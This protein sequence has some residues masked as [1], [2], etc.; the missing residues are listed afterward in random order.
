MHAEEFRSRFSHKCR[1]LLAVDEQNRKNHE[2]LMKAF[3]APD[4]A[5]RASAEQIIPV[6]AHALFI[7]QS[8]HFLMFLTKKVVVVVEISRDNLHSKA[9]HVTSDILRLLF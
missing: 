6:E 7:S 1:K 5:G 4:V 2:Q 3:L 8:R 9:I